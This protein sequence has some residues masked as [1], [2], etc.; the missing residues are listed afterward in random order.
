MMFDH[1]TCNAIVSSEQADKVVA[2]QERQLSIK[3]KV[4]RSDRGPDYTAKMFKGTLERYGIRQEFAPPDGHNQ[5]GKAEKKIAD[6]CEKGKVLLVNANLPYAFFF[7]ALR[8]VTQMHNR[9][10]KNGEQCPWEALGLP[11]EKR[12]REPLP[13][14]CLVLTTELERWSK[15]EPGRWIKTAYL[16][17]D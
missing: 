7:H 9:I 15:S 17:D 14:G 6:I 10:A 2:F 8:L 13:F 12:T 5:L 1:P 16:G 4:L 11:A 3:M